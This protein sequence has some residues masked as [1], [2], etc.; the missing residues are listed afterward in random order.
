MTKNQ[1]IERLRMIRL[2][3]CPRAGLYSIV[4]FMIW[5]FE[6]ANINQTQIANSWSN[7]QNLISESIELL[8][9]SMETES[10]RCRANYRR[11]TGHDIAKFLNLA[12]GS[13]ERQT[14][15][16]LM[17]EEIAYFIDPTNHIQIQSGRA[18]SY[19]EEM[20]VDM[21]CKRFINEIYQTGG[22]FE[23]A[24]FSLSLR[25]AGYFGQTSMSST[26]DAG[27]V[28][29]VISRFSAVSDSDYTIVFKGLSDNLKT[30]FE[31]SDPNTNPWTTY[32]MLRDIL[33]NWPRTEAKR[34]IAFH[35]DKDQLPLTPQT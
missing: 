27:C 19:F 17:S 3:D 18:R 29:I 34:I 24:A 31:F 13:L 7:L 28:T 32:D 12:H 9:K 2:E 6:R 5:Y 20:L 11:A 30:D 35:F 1:L 15:L 16:Y 10:I 25:M 33:E 4:Q 26:N 22:L 14:F 8:A 21:M 23:A